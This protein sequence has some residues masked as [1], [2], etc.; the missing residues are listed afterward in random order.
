MA[1]LQIRRSTGSSAPTSLYP[2]ELAFSAGLD[3]LYIGSPVTGGLLAVT[4]T[5]A[6]GGSNYIS[7]DVGTAV[8]L[9]GGMGSGSAYNY[10]AMKEAI[11]DSGLEESEVSNF[12]TGIV[13]G[14]GGPSIEN[15]ILA[16][17]KTRAK[18]P[19]LMGPFIVPRTMAST[20]SATLAVPFKIKV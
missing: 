10:I 13:M 7:D 17:D 9:T 5:P 16:A 6:A 15:V 14:S 18:T 2:G 1:R 8:N 3:S 19:K 20:A 12:K 4:T 11:E